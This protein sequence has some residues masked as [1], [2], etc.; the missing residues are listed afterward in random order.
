MYDWVRIGSKCSV[1]GLKGIVEKTGVAG[2]EVVVVVVQVDHM[3]LAFEGSS[4]AEVVAGA[5]S[6]KTLTAAHHRTTFRC[7]LEMG[8]V[9]AM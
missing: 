9:L 6:R 4:S 8:K 7:V 3:E 5:G 1:L 2:V